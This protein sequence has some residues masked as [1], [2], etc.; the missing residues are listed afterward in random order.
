VVTAAPTIVFVPVP[1]WV[2]GSSFPRVIGE[3]YPRQ[4]KTPSGW[5][6]R[7]EIPSREARQALLDEARRVIARRREERAWRE[8]AS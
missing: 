2:G 1:V 5:P 3:R 4:S 7:Q 8:L 6:L